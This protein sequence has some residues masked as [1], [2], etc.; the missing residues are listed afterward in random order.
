MNEDRIKLLQ[1]LKKNDIK[2]DVPS[3]SSKNAAFLHHLVLDHKCLSGLEIGTAHAYSSIWLGD[4]FEKNGGRLSTIEHSLPSFNQA[5][6][7]LYRAKLETT[8]TQYFGRAQ[9][10][11]EFELS[12]NSIF[13]F[14]FIDGIKK[15]TLDFFQ[16]TSPLLSPKGIIVIDDVIKF[17]TKMKTFYDWIKS[18]LDWEFA[19]EKLDEDD[20]IMVIKRV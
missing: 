17:E 12:S 8:V 13:D 7:N 16:L 2:T 18:Q 15:S 14:I 9:Q 1:Q 4:A 10:I 5:K 3:I 20:G 11:I 19:I 6:I